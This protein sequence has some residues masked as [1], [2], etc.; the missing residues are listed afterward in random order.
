MK[1]IAKPI[2][3]VAWFDK[4]G[5]HPVRFKFESEDGNAVIKLTRC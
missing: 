4:D 2:D 1:V 5:V 3:T